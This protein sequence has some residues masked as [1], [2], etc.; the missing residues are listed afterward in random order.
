MLNEEWLTNGALLRHPAPVMGL[1][2]GEEHE[3]WFLGLLA[4]VVLA[5]FVALEVLLRSP[6]GRAIR[7]VR[8]DDIVATTLGK[9]VVMLRVKAFALGG[10][11]IGVAGAFHA[12]YLTYIDP[13]QFSATITAYV[14]M[15]VIA[16][17]RG[18]NRG[19]LLG[20]STIMVFIEGS[21]F[22]KDIIPALDSDRLAAIRII[23]IGVGLILLLIY[24]PQGFSREYRLD[25]QVAGPRAAVRV[26][27]ARHPC[28]RGRHGGIGLMSGASHLPAGECCRVSTSNTRPVTGRF[29]I[30]WRCSRTCLPRSSNIMGLL[31]D[32]KRSEIP[33]WRYVELAIVV[34]PSSTSVT[35]CVAHHTAPLKVEGLSTQPSACCLPCT[36]SS[37][38]SI[39]SSSTTR[40][41]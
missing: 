33:N 34:T 19:L 14:F 6:F 26:P 16:G 32:L 9:N 10:A 24:R 29:A 7:A 21:R 17:G 4:A 8:E 23:I 18:S 12:Y 20:A 22:L 11:I 35:H 31:L 15:A 40:L 1:G 27:G 25:Y 13:S 36:R 2:V 41:R 5:L 3:A 37:T 39:G 38:R 30:R 28:Q